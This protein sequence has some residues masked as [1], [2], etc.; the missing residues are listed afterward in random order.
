MLDLFPDEKKSFVHD[1]LL[2]PAYQGSAEKLITALLEGT[3][4][5]GLAATRSGEVRE[6]YRDEEEEYGRRNVFDEEEIDVSKLQ[7]GKNRCV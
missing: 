1:A 3:L 5:P 7:I 2:H 6:P 4:P